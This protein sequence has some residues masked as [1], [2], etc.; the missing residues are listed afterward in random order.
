[1]GRTF[2][3]AHS[4]S[5]LEIEIAIPSRKK[6]SESNALAHTKTANGSNSELRSRILKGLHSESL[7]SCGLCAWFDVLR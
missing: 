2:N 4:D 6:A 5:S 1:M 3:F 7:F